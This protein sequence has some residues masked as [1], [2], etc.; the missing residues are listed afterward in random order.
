MLSK[1]RFFLRDGLSSGEDEESDFK[2]LILIK[3]RFESA[4]ILLTGFKLLRMFPPHQNYSK[5]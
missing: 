5:P 2:Y 4:E 1:R 3:N